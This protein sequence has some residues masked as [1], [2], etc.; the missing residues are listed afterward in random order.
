M[1]YEEIE[2]IKSN[3]KVKLNRL[4]KMIFSENVLPVEI[5]TIFCPK[6]ELFPRKS[7]Y[8][9]EVR[10]NTCAYD[11]NGGQIL[12][13]EGKTRTNLAIYRPDFLYFASK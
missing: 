9:P 8:Q 3:Q 10:F 1:S 5:S 6:C 4:R 13:G 11:G 2:D 7:P 12:L